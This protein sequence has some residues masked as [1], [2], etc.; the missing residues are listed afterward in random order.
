VATSSPNSA[1]TPTY[2][3]RRWLHDKY[4]RLASDEASL[5][6]SRTSYFAAIASGLVAAFVVLVVNELS[7]PLL[8]LVMTTL[9]AIFGILLAAIWTIV[10]RRTAA[11][12]ALFRESVL[13]LERDA[14]PIGASVPASVTLR[15]GETIQIDLTR[16]YLAHETRFFNAPGL[17]WTDRVRPAELSANVPVFLV[18]LWIAVEVGTVVWFLFLQ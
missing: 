12:Q 8:L 17:T 3:E 5:G 6:D 10:L 13:L 18:V 7:R 15:P 11:A 9:L 2:E 4:E 14:P 1:A 16:P